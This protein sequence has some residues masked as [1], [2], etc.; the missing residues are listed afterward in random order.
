MRRKK[1]KV[2]RKPLMGPP[3]EVMDIKTLARYLTM[4]RS[5]IYGLI[6]LKRIPASRSA[7]SIASPRNSST[8]GCA[9]A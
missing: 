3:P 9:S 2:S 4:G 7:G 5:K 6:R 1:R 8:S